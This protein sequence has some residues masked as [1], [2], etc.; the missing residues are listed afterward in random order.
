MSQ[1]QSNMSS[2]LG[3]LLA[4]SVSTVEGCRE[5]PIPSDLELRAIQHCKAAA[6]A[7]SPHHYQPI[8]NDPSVRRLGDDRYQVR[9][10]V[11][12][13]GTP[14]T[15]ECQ[16]DDAKGNMEFQGLSVVHR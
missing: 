13:Q 1:A 14:Q 4:L 8:L 16:L 15:F 10:T 9:A 7:V 11:N 12:G 5:N 2:R 6:L 3:I